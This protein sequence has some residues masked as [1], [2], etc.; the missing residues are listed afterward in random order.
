M[1]DDKLLLFFLMSSS[2]CLM[3]SF[4]NSPIFDLSNAQKR[5]TFAASSSTFEVK[6]FKLFVVDFKH[7]KTSLD[8]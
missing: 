2:I 6:L 7:D 3:I 1:P 5:S 8:S 4:G